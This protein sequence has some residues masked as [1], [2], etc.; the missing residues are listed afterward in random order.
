M[1]KYEII[2][3]VHSHPGANLTYAHFKGEIKLI[4]LTLSH[5]M[6]DDPSASDFKV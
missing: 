4:F 3:I 6:S 5:K 1:I 2:N